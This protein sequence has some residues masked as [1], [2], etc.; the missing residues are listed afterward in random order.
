MKADKG[1]DMAQNMA[2]GVALQALGYIAAEEEALTRL[3]SET[4]VGADTLRAGA[5][6]PELLGAV[7]D[8]LFG[9]ETLL[10]GFCRAQGLTPNQ[11]IHAR[12][13]LPGGPGDWA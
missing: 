1:H 10:L 3:M 5:G 4:G 11:I 2:L 9:D 7:L 8:F 12:A 13:V 6:D